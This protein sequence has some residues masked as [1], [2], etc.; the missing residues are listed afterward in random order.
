MQAVRE[1]WR[2]REPR[3]RLVIAIGLGALL[4]AA[5]WAYVWDPIVRDRARLVTALPQ[6]RAQAREVAAQ[7]AEVERLRNAARSRGA[8]A[9]PEAAIAA[10]AAALGLGEAIGT[11]T[12][13]GEGRVQVAVKPVAFD[14]LVRLLGELGTQH[15]YAVESLVVR[16]APERGRVH[17]ETLMLRTGATG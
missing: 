7:G 9:A 3:E 1:L 5:L 13:L 10:A 16:A 15:G 6:L 2:A 14:T 17:V 12:A 4:A 11:V 8:P